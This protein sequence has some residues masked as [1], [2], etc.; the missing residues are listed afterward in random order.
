MAAMCVSTAL[1]ELFIRDLVIAH[2]ITRQFAGDMKYRGQVERETESDRQ[3]GFSK[4]LDEL[5]PLVTEPARLLGAERVLRTDAYPFSAWSRSQ[6][7][8]FAR[9]GKR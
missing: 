8:N 5:T 9:H 1:L 7:D 3:M 2:R 6:T 4:M